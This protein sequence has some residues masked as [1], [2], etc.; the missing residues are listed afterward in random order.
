MKLIVSN[1]F[2]VWLGQFKAFLIR[3]GEQQTR[4]IRF[5][6]GDESAFRPASEDYIVNGPYK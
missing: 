5:C 2:F 4:F 3:Q 6:P 1:G